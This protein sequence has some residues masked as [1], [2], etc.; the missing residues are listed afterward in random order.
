ME[1][2]DELGYIRG[3]RLGLQAAPAMRE[4]VDFLLEHKLKSAAQR[5]LEELTEQVRCILAQCS[6]NDPAVAML[7]QSEVYQKVFPLLFQQRWSAE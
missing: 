3:L 5:E 1:S 2:G 6:P 4:M 7:K